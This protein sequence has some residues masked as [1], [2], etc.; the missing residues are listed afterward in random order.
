[1]SYLMPITLVVGPNGLLRI[2]RAIATIGPNL[3]R[4]NAP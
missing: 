2:D 1:M 4:L 3:F